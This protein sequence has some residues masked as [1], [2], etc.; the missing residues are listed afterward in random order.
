M[1]L[2]DLHVHSTVSDGTLSPSEL[3]TYAKSKGLSAIALTDHDSVDGI[4]ECQQKGLELNLM[5][6][7]GI[8]FS[9][10]YCGKEIHML[11]YYINHHDLHFVK[12]LNALIEAR[13]KRNELMLQKLAHMGCP[14]TTEDLIDESNKDSVITRAH[15]AKAMLKKGYIQDRKEAF[16]HYIGDGKPC[17]VPKTPFTTKECIKLI[18]SVGGVA[19]LAHPMLYGYAPS[20]VTQLLRSLKSEGLDGVE[21]LY[22]THTKEDTHHL[23]QVCSN[24][25]LFPTGGSDF[26]GENKPSLDL[27]TGYG[28]LAIPFELLDTMHQY[29]GYIPKK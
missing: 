23:L 22:S 21:C 12:R 13:E 19:V 15:I 16:A 11:G 17:F 18:H 9:V 14:L 7:P 24:L 2:I 4:D 8:E 29:L 10:D 1:K 5:V 3:V 25:Q 27:G 28:E 26:H 6:I 20:D